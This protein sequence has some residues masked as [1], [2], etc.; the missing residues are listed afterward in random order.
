MTGLLIPMC[1]Y[2]QTVKGK[3]TGIAFVDS[4][5]L[6]VCHNIRIPGNKV[7]DGIAQRGKGTMGWF[8]GFKLHLLINHIGEIISLKII[9]GNTNDRHRPLNHAKTSTESFLRIKVQRSLINHSQN[10][11]FN[12]G[13][14]SFNGSANHIAHTAI[15]SNVQLTFIFTIYTHE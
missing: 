5:S 7:F 13:E 2:F 14:V 4:T 3:P 12:F 1:T 8:Y 10:T 6:K 9:P 11:C 15:N